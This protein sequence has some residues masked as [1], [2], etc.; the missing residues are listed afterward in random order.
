MTIFAPSWSFNGTRA[1]GISQGATYCLS[2]FSGSGGGAADLVRAGITSV[3]SSPSKA[4]APLGVLEPDF[5]MLAS[6]VHPAD[7]SR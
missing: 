2:L 1:A 3:G 5:A 7:R 6:S 4:L